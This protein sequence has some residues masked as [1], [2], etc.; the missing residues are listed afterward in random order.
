[1]AVPCRV[2]VMNAFVGKLGMDTS[3]FAFTDVFG[4]DEVRRGLQAVTGRV[5]A[6]G[7]CALLALWA[8]GPRW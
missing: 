4:M 2:Q 5:A 6:G 1:M 7:S 8:A 3:N